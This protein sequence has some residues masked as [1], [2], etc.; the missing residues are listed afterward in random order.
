VNEGRWKARISPAIARERAG[1]H[2]RPTSLDARSEQA[3]HIDCDDIKVDAVDLAEQRAG[4]H[5]S[6]RSPGNDRARSQDRDFVGHAGKVQVVENRERSAASRRVRASECQKLV[7]RVEMR[8]RLV[9]K[10]EGGCCPLAS[11][12]AA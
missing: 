12:T 9:E 11:P 10:Q 4:R 2:R 5:Q 6:R 1:L 8:G 7:G 3:A